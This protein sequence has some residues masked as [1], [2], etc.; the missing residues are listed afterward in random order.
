MLVGQRRG[1]G[2]GLMGCKGEEGGGDRLVLLRVGGSWRNFGGVLGS[3]GGGVDGG[4]GGD[5]FYIRYTIF[6]ELDI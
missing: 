2:V 4:M 5:M 1:R 3:F 6:V